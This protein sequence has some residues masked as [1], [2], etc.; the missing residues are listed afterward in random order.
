MPRALL[1]V[2]D[3][4]GLVEFAT[5]L[6]RFGFELVST[7][8][9][10]EVLMEAG[11]P[12]TQVSSV[13]GFTEFLGGRVKTLHPNIHGG[14]LAQR[15]PE[16]LAELAAFDITPIDLVAVNL[17]PFR[18]TV[19][20]DDASLGTILEAIDIGGPTMIRAA[21][22]NFEHVLV[23]VDPADYP[24]ILEAQA[25]GV[26][27]ELRR[28]LAHKAF[29][30]TA[31]YD[32]AIASYFNALI[33]GDGLPETLHFSLERVQELRY[34]ENP[35]Q[36]GARYHEV[37]T[38]G[39]WEELEQHGGVALSYLNMLDAEAAWR[40]VFEFET[41]PCAVVIKHANPC[42]VALDETI[43][44]AYERAFAADPKSAFG[45]VVALN[46]L[47][48]EALAMKIVANPKADVVI[49]PGFE[50][51]ALAVLTRK[52][53]RMRTLEAPPPSRPALELRQLAGGFLAQ[54]P[55]RVGLDRAAWQVV[56]RV[57]PTPDQWRDL[58]MAWMVCA[59]SSSNAIVLVK[60][61]QGVG[62]GVGQQSR[63]DAALLAV[64]K[65]DGRARG[66]ACA[67]DAF[68]PFRDGLDVVAEAGVAAVIQPG[69]S[70][71][72]PELI[73]AA[74]EHGVAMVL[75]GERHFRH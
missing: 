73:E 57:Q 42:G 66:G 63:V 28:K 23:I 49:A 3:K 46:R 16:H 15:T 9:T 5:G 36:P 24:R 8:G 69:G 62:I 71:R 34:G 48:S 30:H 4:T 14:L 11:L 70:V 64:N 26:T 59:H 32:G 25:A 61:G 47:V 60:D 67:S 35:H 10:S 37:G 53:K 41:S 33:G 65:A 1:S 51:E 27:L 31:A 58:E 55:D 18:E 40:L 29:A 39:F 72:D 74:D 43:E 17:Y 22:K 68:F 6:Q 75:T 52:R 54:P 12:V 19:G 7:G 44:S 2:S 50:P 38:R 45:G 13:T 20:S 56:T 21:A